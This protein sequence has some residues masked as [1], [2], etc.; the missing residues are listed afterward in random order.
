MSAIREVMR[1]FMPASRNAAPA[2]ANERKIV[3][4][5]HYSALATEFY[6]VHRARSWPVERAVGEAYER[7]I[8]VYK[9][10]EVI[11]SAASRLPFHL[12]RGESIVQ[13]HPLARVL[14][15]KANPL[16]TGSQFRKRLSQQILLSKRGAFVEITRSEG[17]ELLRLDLLPPG[18]T[19]PVPGDGEELIK[20]YEV[21][22]ADG[23]IKRI[24]TENVRWFRDPHPLDPFCGVTPLEAAGLS[25]EL[26]FFARLTNVAFLKNDSRPGGVLA[27]DGEMGD[28][29]MN[30]VERRF[31]KGAPNAGSLAV[32]QGQVSYVDLAVRPRDM[33]HETTSSIAKKEI[34]SAFGVPESVIGDASGRSW[35]NAEQEE[36]NFWSIT[37]PPHLMLLLTGLDEDSED[38]LIGE[39]DTSGIAVLQ[40]AAIARR[41]EAREEFEKGLI[42][43]NEYRDLAGYQ[44]VPTRQGRSIFLPGGRV[45]MPT[46]DADVKQLEKEGQQK[47]E[48]EQAAKTPPAVK[49]PSAAASGAKEP[50]RT[51]ASS[52]QK[53]AQGSGDTGQA[54]PPLARQ[55]RPERAREG[56]NKSHPLVALPGGGQGGGRLGGAQ[57][58]PTIRL[59][60]SA[61][62]KDAAP[63]V[64]ESPPDEAAY[65]RLE[66]ALEVA[67]AALGVRLTARA[68]TRLNSPKAR[69]GTR[70]WQPDGAT[71]TRLGTK[72]LDIGQAVEPERWAQET[73]L[74]A[75]PLVENAATEAARALAGDLTGERKQADPGQSVRGVVDGVVRMLRASAIRQADALIEKLADEEQR[76]RPVA[77]LVDKARDYAKPM[78]SWA[79]AVASHAATA[80][81]NGAREAAASVTADANPNMDIERLWRTRGDAD[82]RMSH[83]DAA[84]Q[85]RALGHPFHVGEAQLRYPGDEEGPPGEVFGCRCR[86]IF[87]ATASGRFTVAPEGEIS[88]NPYLDLA[89][90]GTEG[91]RLV[92]IPIQL[93]KGRAFEE[94]LHP[95]ENDGKFTDNPGGG[96]ESAAVV[97]D[98]R[99]G[100][101]AYASVPQASSMGLT[102]EEA[103]AVR[104]YTGGA[105]VDANDLLR[106]AE[107]FS[108]SQRRRAE[109]L[110][111]QLDDAFKKVTPLSEPIVVNRT[112]SNAEAIFGA[113]GSRV[114]GEFRDPAFVSTTTGSIQD[115]SFVT[116]GDA[117]LVFTL[118]A[119][120]KAL[121]P[122]ELGRPIEKEV[123][124]DREGAFRVTADR[125]IDGERVIDLEQLPGGR[126]A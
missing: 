119:G 45:E 86:V 40:R 16:E 37:M 69:K 39:F 105:Y 97:S 10:V 92:H 122:G 102:S 110:I 9:A 62:T 66:A 29:E 124:L 82:V 112:V 63:D 55:K 38:D 90:T 116:Q 6:N 12:K 65:E 50:A 51:A 67:L 93:A 5:D 70:H 31:A 54:K 100:E 15:K 1:R 81:I 91:K 24:P 22:R 48:R 109:Q 115:L 101:S 43:A 85:T 33:Q 88:R 53:P 118:P 98:V 84:G 77:E 25:I 103:Q 30:R 75:Q 18:R 125:L 44:E 17:G 117:R 114:G 7:I 19:V 21:V 20:R 52:A 23:S 120:S 36:H 72:V 61:E 35:D 87:R 57:A 32:V 80:T 26:D 123:L 106:G 11:A 47:F 79:R 78:A 27:V 56:S 42:S 68:A 8:W 113:V 99:Q 14:N 64:R 121:A 76:L 111:G 46:S 83:K 41:A 28:E 4:G 58:K 94:R 108:V 73:A 13:D 3:L 2:R 104:R 126:D 59:I 74:A 96:P 60:R 71:D 34:L 107:D 89:A 95:R 49:V